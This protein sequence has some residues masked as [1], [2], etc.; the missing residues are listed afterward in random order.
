MDSSKE[1]APHKGFTHFSIDNILKAE[2]KWERADKEKMDTSELTP[3]KVIDLGSTISHSGVLRDLE[4][5]AIINCNNNSNSSGGHNVR[6]YQRRNRT[7]FTAEQ[8]EELEKAFEKTQY[9]D[10]LTREELAERL[11]I[12]ES[13]IQVWFSNHRS[14]SKSKKFHKPETDEEKSPESTKT[15]IFYPSYPVVPVIRYAPYPA[16]RVFPYMHFRPI[17]MMTL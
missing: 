11:H 16:A 4:S 15:R 9:P 3:S 17:Q 5:P 6:L 7:K 2:D 12:S 1:N 13:K 8:V 10:A 14:K